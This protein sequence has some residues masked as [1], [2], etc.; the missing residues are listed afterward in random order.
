MSEEV[1]QSFSNLRK[2]KWEE[3][4][5]VEGTLLDV[6]DCHHDKYGRFFVWIIENKIPGEYIFNNAITYQVAD[7]LTIGSQIRVTFLGLQE[8]GEGK[9]AMKIFKVDVLDW[10]SGGGGYVCDL[11]AN[12]E[13]GDE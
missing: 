9:N 5:S 3:G 11:I 8:Q 7:K 12:D 10:G 13:K 4:D 2:S 6:R 1:K